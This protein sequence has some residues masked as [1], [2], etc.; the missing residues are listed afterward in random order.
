MLAT[1]CIQAMIW[2]PKVFPWWFAW[3]G[4]TSS[5]LCT[6][7]CSAESAS[8]SSQVSETQQQCMLWMLSEEN[9][10][11][12]ACSLLHT[13]WKEE[14]QKGTEE[15]CGLQ[16]K[17]EAEHLLCWGVSRAA[18]TAPTGAVR[19]VQQQLKRLSKTLHCVWWTPV[20]MCLIKVRAGHDYLI[21]CYK[22]PDCL[23]QH[24]TDE[25]N[26]DPNQWSSCIT[27]AFLMSLSS[28]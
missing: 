21:T 9:T 10:P 1:V 4:R 26:E 19:E 25:R 23:R 8:F 18:S 5:V 15:P 17:Q 28:I 22:S 14:K 16:G 11:S 13:Q 24:W 27:W 12:E 6:W 3:G 20:Q 7:V 2:P